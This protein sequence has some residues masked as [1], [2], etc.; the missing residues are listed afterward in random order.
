MDYDEAR[1]FLTDIAKLGSIRLPGHCKERMRERDVA[2]D[3]LCYVLLWGTIQ[4][5]E[6]Q[7]DG[8]WKCKVVGLDIDGDE[9]TFVTVFDP[10]ER[11]I[12]C[13]TVF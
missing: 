10:K 3:D 4:E 7:D 8:T 12:L 9:L 11:F 5:L 1:N 2:T 13:V 6:F